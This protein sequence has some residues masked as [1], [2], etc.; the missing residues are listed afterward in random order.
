MRR[1]KLYGKAG[2]L[3]LA[4]MFAVKAEAQVILSTTPQPQQ[5]GTWCWA[6]SD[7]EI[8]QAFGDNRSQCS[9]ASTHLGRDCCR[10]PSSCNEWGIPNPGLFGKNYSYK[11][12]HLTQSEILNAINTLGKPF[13]FSWWIYGNNHYMVGMGQDFNG[14]VLIYHTNHD[15]GLW[16]TWFGSGYVTY[17]HALSPSNSVNVRPNP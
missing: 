11:N 2:A 3:A 4:L 7:R 10:N 17:N 14:E 15:S 16:G 8:L 1:L 9:I 5:Q 12:G 6:A 13:A